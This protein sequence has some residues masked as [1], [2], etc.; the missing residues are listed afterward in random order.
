MSEDNNPFLGC[1]G[2]RLA[3]TPNIDAL[4]KRGILYRHTFSAAP[5]CAPSRFGI[6]TGM[7][8]ESCAPANQMRANANRRRSSRDAPR[9]SARSRLLL[10]NNAKTDFN[11]DA[12]PDRIFD[13]SGPRAHYKNRPAGK[14][15]FA[16]FN[17]ES[18]H[19]SCL[20]P[21]DTIVG[22]GR[23]L[24][25]RSGA[26]A[27][28]AVRFGG[29]GMRPAPMSGRVRPRMFVCRRT[30]PT[31][32]KPGKTA[33]ATT[34]RSRSWTGRW[35]KLKELDAA[36]LADDTIVFYYSDNG[37]VLPR[38]KRYCYD[39]GLRCAMV[40]AFPPKW[41]HLA[42]AKMGSES[43]RASQLRRP[44]THAPLADRCARPAAD[45]GHG[46]LGAARASAP[47]ATP[48]ACGTGWTNATTSSAP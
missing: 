18:S 21:A 30:C 34:T 14:P 29:A 3:H 37:G 28:A 39:D 48:S 5:V 36:G 27:A 16:V 40:V 31:L 13:E 33:R 26:G 32:R 47:E 35:A 46:V 4:A 20:S 23:A 43:D 10:T 1:Y 42:P 12:D 7:H 25:G 45:A 17:H 15:F 38:S 6:L 2:D 19:E 9:V 44:G 24:G 11:C 22:G 41:V 8:A